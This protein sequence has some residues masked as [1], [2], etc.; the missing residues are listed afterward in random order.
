MRLQSKFEKKER[1]T[2]RKT[3]QDGLE[4]A[5]VFPASKGAVHRLDE[6]RSDVCAVCGIRAKPMGG[7]LIDNLAQ[8]PAYSPHN[9]KRFRG[10]VRQRDPSDILLV[11]GAHSAGRDEGQL[12]TVTPHVFAPHVERKLTVSTEWPPSLWHVAG[13]KHS[14]AG[15]LH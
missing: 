3:Y 5:A 11:E 9:K 6:A 2:L 12:A 8:V 13:C 1:S 14:S 7:F 15:K 10:N 4:V